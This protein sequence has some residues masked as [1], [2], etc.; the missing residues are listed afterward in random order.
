MID[1]RLIPLH[2]CSFC[3]YQC[4]ISNG[5]V[6]VEV[7]MF[8]TSYRHWKQYVIADLHLFDG[9]SAD[10]CYFVVVQMLLVPTV[11]PEAPSTA[12]SSER[13]MLWA[14]FMVLSSFT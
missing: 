11:N 12:K 3:T 14:Y 13:V 8:I 2:L 10:S 9:D 6:I 1:P 4:L 7:I 5:A